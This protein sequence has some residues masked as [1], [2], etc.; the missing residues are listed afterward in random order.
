[1]VTTNKKPVKARRLNAMSDDDMERGM[2]GD[3]IPIIVN[4]EVS[5]ADIIEA[6]RGKIVKGL[7]KWL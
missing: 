4:N 3:P 7:E 1:M 2:Q 6:N 5:L